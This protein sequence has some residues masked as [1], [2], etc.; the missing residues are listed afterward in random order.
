MSLKRIQKELEEIL[1]ESTD[2]ISAKPSK[3]NNLFEWDAKIL[4]P[5]KSP[6]SCGEFILKIHIP[7]NY[8]FHPKD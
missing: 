2:N 8:P 7:S 1:K 5:E 6:Y 4:G 3:D